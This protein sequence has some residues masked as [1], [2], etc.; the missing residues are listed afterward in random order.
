MRN[1]TVAAPELKQ[2]P[3]RKHRR[4]VKPTP[5]PSPKV[6]VHASV[7]VDYDNRHTSFE[8][9]EQHFESMIRQQQNRMRG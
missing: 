5:A 9:Q 1:N 3:N 8:I 4:A 6:V 2:D 7:F